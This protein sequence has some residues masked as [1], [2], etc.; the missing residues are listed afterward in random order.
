MTQWMCIYPTIHF[1][2]NKDS[3]TPPHQRQLKTK[4]DGVEKM[5][6]TISNWILL[7]GRNENVEQTRQ[8]REK[9][10]FVKLTSDKMDKEKKNKVIKPRF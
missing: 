7:E 2:P 1:Y 5:K 8:T 10:K 6:M 4:P 9:K 3:D